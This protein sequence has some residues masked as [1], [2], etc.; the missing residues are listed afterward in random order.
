ME[1]PGCSCKLSAGLVCILGSLQNASPH[2]NPAWLS[3]T[4][5]KPTCFPSVAFGGMIKHFSTLRAG[6]T[7]SC[8]ADIPG[9]DR[10]PCLPGCR[11]ASLCV[12]QP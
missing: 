10:C 6:A 1:L 5:T 2:V 3:P 12:L 9:L 8:S 11:P 7:A 4:S